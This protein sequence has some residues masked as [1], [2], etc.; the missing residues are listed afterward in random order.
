MTEYKMSKTTTASTAGEVNTPS[1]PPKPKSIPLH[2]LHVRP[3]PIRT[4]PL[5]VF[6]PNNPVS[7][8]HLVYAW[9]KH[10]IF[11]PPAEPSTVH[12]GIWDPATRSVHIRDHA[13]MRALW[14]QGFY[15]KGSLSR[16]EPNWLKREQIRRGEVA[17]NVIEEHTTS[18]REERRV[19][20]WERARV[21][22]EAIEQTRFEESQSAADVLKALPTGLP[23]NIPPKIPVKPPVGPM[24]LL[25]LPNSLSDL[26]DAKGGGLPG[27]I[28]RK[29]AV[30]PPVGPAELLALPNSTSDLHDAE[31]GIKPGDLDA[32]ELGPSFSNGTLLP[33]PAFERPAAEA[34]GLPNGPDRSESDESHAGHS[35]GEYVNGHLI[36]PSES[37]NGTVSWSDSFP[38]DLV[39]KSGPTGNEPLKHRK[40]VRFSPKVES[41]TYKVSDPPSPSHSPV[42]ARKGRNGSAHLVNGLAAKSIETPLDIEAAIANK[43]HLQ[44]SPEEAFFLVFAIGALTVVD[45]ATNCPIPTENLLTLLRAHSHFPPRALASPNLKPHD[46]FLVHYSVYHH[47]RSLGW[48]PRHGI[49][50]GVDWM[51]YQRGPA[52]DHAEFGVIVVPSFSDPWWAEHG[53]RPAQKSWQWF[54]AV[55]RVL[56]HVMKSLVLVYVDVPPPPAFDAAMAN[57]GQ[58]GGLAAALKK[59]RIREILARRWSSNRN[60]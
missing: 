56:S 37:L 25:A 11:P 44:L 33:P 59:Y 26:H 8:V 17:G 4:F 47:F 14:E 1:E 34:P 46:P 35:N 51:L 54:H 53:H 15:G 5:P 39:S 2:Q 45:P 28:P 16:S 22:Q 31:D 32:Q 40:S 12:T 10:A 24:E 19:A 36:G 30:K 13:S 42:V 27:I 9:L 58:D 41:T 6:Y 29:P 3:A 23:G 43:E 38:P 21:A 52:F 49:K 57:S 48:V 18:R 55:N 20:K 50:F 60:R 7:L